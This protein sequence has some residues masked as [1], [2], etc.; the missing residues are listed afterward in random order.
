MPKLYTAFQLRLILLNLEIYELEGV[1]DI[2]NNSHFTG[3]YEN[4]RPV[5]LFGDYENYRRSP[6]ME[7]VEI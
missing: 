1:G 3:F 6:K 4:L 7:S 5:S 2:V